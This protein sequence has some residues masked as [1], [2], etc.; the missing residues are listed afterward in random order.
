MTSLTR[1]EELSRNWEPARDSMS[2]FLSALI[3][4]SSLL[5]DTWHPLPSKWKCQHIQEWTEP[6]LISEKVIRTKRSCVLTKSRGVLTTSR[7]GRDGSDCTSRGLEDCG[8]RSSTSN[9]Q[10]GVTKLAKWEQEKSARDVL[11]WRLHWWRPFS[12][13]PWTGYAHWDCPE[14]AFDL[15]AGWIIMHSSN[16]V[17]LGLNWNLISE[18]QKYSKW[19]YKIQV[20]SDEDKNLPSK[21]GCP[22]GF[23]PTSTLEQFFSREIL[24]SPHSTLE[25]IHN[26]LW[27]S[28]NHIY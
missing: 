10:S 7:L 18:G 22:H 3:C 6:L 1:R 16:V 17:N 4:F 26:N 19:K 27:G 11:V 25:R 20:S 12:I 14:T 21:R 23:S 8:V 15:E 5:V 13:Q 9:L 28:S 2:P 24:V